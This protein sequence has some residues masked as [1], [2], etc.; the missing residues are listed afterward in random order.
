MKQTFTT[1]V[2][3]SEGKNATGLHVPPQIIAA[4]NSGKRPGQ[5]RASGYFAK[6][7]SALD[8]VRIVLSRIRPQISRCFVMPDLR[9]AQH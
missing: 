8:Q 2:F 4:F 1:T 6:R 5:C 9:S 3:Q 7:V